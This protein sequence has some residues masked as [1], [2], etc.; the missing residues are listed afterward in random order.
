MQLER[1][2]AST[3]GLFIET[4]TYSK[5]TKGKIKITHH[6]PSASNN[7]SMQ[8][9]VT[10]ELNTVI[11]EVLSDESSSERSQTIVATNAGLSREG[12]NL[13]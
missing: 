10:S 8:A 9:D 4:T 6:P 5:T 3:Y 11:E 12:K 13:M 1:N 7:K 2:S